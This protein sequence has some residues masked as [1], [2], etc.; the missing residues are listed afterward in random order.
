MQE[1]LTNVIKHAQASKV[2][3]SVASIEGEVRIEVQDD[4]LGFDPAVRSDGFG[5]AGMRERVYLAGGTVEL[6]SGENGTLVRARLPLQAENAASEVG[7][8]AS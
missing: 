1:S 7:A 2:R 3:V 8:A 4:G 6:Q 5:L